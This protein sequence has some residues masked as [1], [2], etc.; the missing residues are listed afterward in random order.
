MEKNT[1][2]K[3]I[4]DKVGRDKAIELVLN[5]YNTEL[6]ASWLRHIEAS[7]SGKNVRLERRD[8]L[9]NAIARVTEVCDLSE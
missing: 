3:K 6:V 1:S 7:Q 8:H 2:M 9:A 5:A 4:S